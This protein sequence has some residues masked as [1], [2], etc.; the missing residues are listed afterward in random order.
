ME[1]CPPRLSVRRRKGNGTKNGAVRRHWMRL[2]FKED[3]C[4]SAS[5]DVTSFFHLE[6]RPSFHFLTS[7]TRGRTIRDSGGVFQKFISSQSLREFVDQRDLP[8]DPQ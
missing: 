7:E 6:S 1:A 3:C 2:H 5:R 4:R 8:A